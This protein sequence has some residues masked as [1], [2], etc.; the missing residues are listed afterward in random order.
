MSKKQ[1]L[2]AIRSDSAYPTYRGFI[3]IIALLGYILAGIVALGAV[4]TGLFSMNKSA[5]TGI[6]I[7]V[8]GLIYAAI[9]FLMAR[10][11][12]EA[13]LILADIGDSTVDANSRARNGH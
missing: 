3:G 9:L 7:M 4:G 11:F 13:A 12:K 1:Y 2:E 8:G 6:A 10:F 5:G